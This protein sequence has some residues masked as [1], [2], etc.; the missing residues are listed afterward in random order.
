LAFG[1]CSYFPEACL[2]ANASLKSSS[3]PRSIA[4]LFNFDSTL[5]EVPPITPIVE[6]DRRFGLLLPE[7]ILLF[8]FLSAWSS[9]I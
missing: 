3:D 9:G 2:T 6:L 8:I 4:K 7:L 5:G 1:F